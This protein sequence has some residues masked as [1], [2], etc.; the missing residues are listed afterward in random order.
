MIVLRSLRPL[1]LASVL[2]APCLLAQQKSSTPDQTPAS[3]APTIA[4]DARLVNLP[5]V[6]RDKKGALI[7]NLTKDDFVLQVDGKP[8]TVRYFDKDTNLPLTLG[9]LVDTS[10]SQ[11]DVIDEERT[12]SS[13]FLDQMLTTPK[14]KAFIM[15]FATETEL[16]QD[17]TSSRP[18][19]QAALK[20]IDT[21][22]KS[23]GSSGDD[24]SGR[25]PRGGGGTVLYD[26]LFLASDELMSKQTGRKAIII[27]SD[28]G[29]RGSRE[30]LVKSIEAAQRADT[31][32]YAIYFKGEQ[33]HQD[34]PQHG[35]GGNPGGGGGGYPGGGYPGGRYPGGGY[36]GGGYPG[37]GYPGGGNGGGNNGGNYPNGRS[38]TDGKKIL[39]RMAQ[40]TGGRLFEVKKNLDV[41]QI[42]QQ[43]AEELRAQ[44]RLGYTP[45][46]DAATSGYHKIDLTLHQKGL[47]IQT[48]DGYYT[49]K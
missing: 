6:V 38:R 15:Q 44:Y 10:A 2:L 39:E 46:Q 4:V 3:T 13:T 19:L 16:L 47:L 31:I 14:D 28:G 30:T 34:F 45:S 17:I 21:P 20:E 9:L 7:Q 37:G 22:G 11:R 40:E 24:T 48:R 25:R 35:G 1:L 41:A 26:A 29:D 43:I 18:L 5:V 36:P 49:G 23:S 12:A 8:Q 33:P 32:I 42:Y 27:L